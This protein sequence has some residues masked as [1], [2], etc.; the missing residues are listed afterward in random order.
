[1]ARR[2][3]Q[4]GSIETNNGWYVCR[5][6][7]DIPG[8]NERKHRNVKICPVSGPGS[9]NRAQRKHRAREIVEESGADTAAC[10]LQS[11]I[12]NLG[13]TFRQQADWWI[14]NVQQRKRRPV[15]ERTAKTWE[16]YLR[17]PL[18]K[19]GFDLLT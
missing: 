7:Q 3:G 8:Q 10:L 15:K 13:T 4:S 6:W 9:M 16:S 14:Q 11:V 2:S 5:F 1:M 19:L 12:A 17:S 18:S